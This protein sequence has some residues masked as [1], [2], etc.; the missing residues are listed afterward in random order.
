MLSFRFI[1]KETKNIVNF[2]VAVKLGLIKIT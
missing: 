1:G 2:A